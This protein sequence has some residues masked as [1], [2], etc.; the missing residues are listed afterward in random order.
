LISTVFTIFL[1][2]ALLSLVLDIV[3]GLKNLFR[4]A[5]AQTAAHGR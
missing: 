2:P 4:P 3:S 5:K 1:I